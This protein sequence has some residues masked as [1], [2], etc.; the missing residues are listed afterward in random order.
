[1]A[2][3]FPFFYGNVGPER[4]KYCRFSCNNVASTL[5]QDRKKRLKYK[6]TFSFD[7][8]S[9]FWNIKYFI[10]SLLV[11]AGTAMLKK[12]KKEAEEVEKEEEVEEEE[13]V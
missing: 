12:R 6:F 2:T 13:E 8:I 9:H 4:R 7:T 3:F 11:T 5:A 10:C 1:M